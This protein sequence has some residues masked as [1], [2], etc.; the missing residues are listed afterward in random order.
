MQAHPI[1]RIGPTTGRT[2]DRMARM[3]RIVLLHVLLPH[4]GWQRDGIEVEPEG[5]GQ[6]A[7]RGWPMIGA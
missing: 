3:Q 1:E 2:G 4:G 6:V 5:S 7:S